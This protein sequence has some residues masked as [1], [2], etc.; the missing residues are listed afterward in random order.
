[1]ASIFREEAVRRLRDPEQLNTALRLSSP[2]SWILLAILGLAVAAVLAWS[3]L[4]RLPFRAEG[5]GVILKRDSLIYSVAAEATGIV[6]AIS[7]KTG[8]EVKEGDPLVTLFQPQLDTEREAAQRVLNDL[9]GQYSRLVAMSQQDIARRRESQVKQQAAIEKSMASVQQD[10]SF[11]R[12]LY[13]TEQGELKQGFI[14][15]DEL[16]ATKARLDD[17]ERNLRDLNNQLTILSIDQIEFENQQE[18]ARLQLESQ[19]IAARNRLADIDTQLKQTR[20]LRSPTDGMVTEI[21][22]KLG[23]QVPAGQSVVVIEEEGSGLQTVAFLPISQGKRVAPGMTAEIGPTS[24][25][26]EIYGT[27]HATVS[28]VSALPVTREGLQAILSNED[29]VEQMLAAGSPIEVRLDL[30]QDAAT[31]SGLRWSS[32]EG[33]AIKITP[34][35]TAVAAITVENRR[36]IDLVVPLYETWLAPR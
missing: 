17:A 24:V 28:S 9:D 36:P 26:R 10:V 35:T 19:I 27:I 20:I 14:T 7:V 33:P 2:A 8:Q 5:M 29:L 13:A 11:L 31:T 4:G 25:E 6:S 15:R 34:G 32:S 16:E 18:L 21:A 22:T 23:A 3:F 12:N 30:S 1:M